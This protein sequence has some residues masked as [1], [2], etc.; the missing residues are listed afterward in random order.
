MSAQNV[1]SAG[2]LA[3]YTG[4]H[5]HHIDGNPMN[6]APENI[7]SLC[8]SHHFLVERGRITMDATFMPAFKISS[9]KRRYSW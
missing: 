6:N 4:M 9:D 5:V 3:E 8:V 2:R 7:V 1:A